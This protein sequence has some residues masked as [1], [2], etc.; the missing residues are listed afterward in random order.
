MNDADYVNAD[1]RDLALRR[2]SAQL[3]S[4]H[5][6]VSADTHVSSIIWHTTV[7]SMLLLQP[8]FDAH[9]SVLRLS[10]FLFTGLVVFTSRL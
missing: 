9:V 7:M 10:P 6:I 3:V 8:S 4:V 1:A 5:P 2:M